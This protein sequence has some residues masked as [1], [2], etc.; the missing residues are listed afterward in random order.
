MS[1]V[2]NWTYHV[3]IIQQETY[4][5]LCRYDNVASS[6]IFIIHFYILRDSNKDFVNILNANLLSFVG[7][8]QCIIS[9]YTSCVYFMFLV[10]QSNHMNEL[11]Q[12][13]TKKLKFLFNYITDL[14]EPVPL[15]RLWFLMFRTYRFRSLKTSITKFKSAKSPGLRPGPIFC[16]GQSLLLTGTGPS[17]G[18]KRFF[19]GKGEAKIFLPKWT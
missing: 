11:Q 4:T 1:I 13:Y 5:I 9:F 2:R 8:N 18:V 15:K 14:H 3:Y 17:T 16:S 6:N 12:I 10:T 7:K 19:G